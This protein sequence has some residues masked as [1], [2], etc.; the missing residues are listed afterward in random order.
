MAR[1]NRRTTDFIVWH[2]SATPPSQDIGA[3]QIQVMHKARGFDDIGYALVI[4][5][6]GRIELGEDFKKRGA[7]VKGFNSV[8]IGI[9][10]IGGVDEDGEPENNYTD[11]QWKAAKHVF[12]FFTLLY[13][14]ADH[15]GHRDL[16]P[17]S[18]NDGRVMRNEFIKACPCFSV[19]AWMENNLEP[20][21]E[22]YAPWEE[23]IVALEPDEETEITFEEV[24]D[25]DYDDD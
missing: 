16:S 1:P 19:A 14:D 12:E 13:P 25:E 23:S 15:V 18:N 4:R 24:L 20:V 10:M 9:C 11:E 17:D 7:H 3:A 8:S 5:R 22:L 2:A 6:D 21:D